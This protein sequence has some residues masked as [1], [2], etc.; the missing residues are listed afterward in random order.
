MELREYISRII[1]EC[2]NESDNMSYTSFETLIGNK[3]IVLNIL[4]NSI[5]VYDKNFLNGDKPENG[6]LGC[7]GLTRGSNG[8]YEASRI[9]GERG[10]GK[11]LY[12]LG[13]EL[14]SPMPLMISRDGDI[15]EDALRVIEKIYKNP[16]AGVE[17]IN[18]DKDDVKYIDCLEDIGCDDE[19][20]LEDF[21]KIYNTV[22]YSKSK[23]IN[24]LKQ[25]KRIMKDKNIDSYGRNYFDFKYF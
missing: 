6:V 17:V 21:F 16:P 8:F 23:Y 10:Y 15:R 11:L 13:M 1:Q 19:N 9:A 22:F 14:A 24:K 5:T 3:D 2:L 7:I 25:E 18:I 20:G 4:G 12:I